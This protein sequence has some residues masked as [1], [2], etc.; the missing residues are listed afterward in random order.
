MSGL[1]VANIDV[2]RSNCL[3]GGVAKMIRS[4]DTGCRRDIAKV[5]G[6]VYCVDEIAIW[7]GNR[8]R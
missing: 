3:Y 4:K 2:A 6:C 8:H 1:G 5:W 7:R